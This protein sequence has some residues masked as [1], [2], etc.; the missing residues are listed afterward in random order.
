[1]KAFVAFLLIAVSSVSVRAVGAQPVPPCDPLQAAPVP[2]YAELGAPAAV[3]TWRD[4]EFDSRDACPDLPPGRVPLVVALASKFDG[5]K[6]LEDI[7]SRIGSI[8]AGQGL[9]YW[10]TTRQQWRT[11]V[12][13]A[14]AL[15]ESDTQQR[16]PDFKAQE[17]LSGETLYFLQNDT[18]S[19][20]RNG[21]ALTAKSVAPDRLIVEI[22]NTTPIRF[23][24]ITLFEPY[25]LRSIHY[26]DRLESNAWG[27]YG[28][29]AVR[30]DGTE[31]HEKSFVNR[32]GAY[33]RF[34]TETP[35]DREPPLAP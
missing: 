26:I 12:S 22:V 33:Y 24:L 29:M 21:Y 20:G 25:A 5:A 28:V 13:E 23:A 35:S 15:T 30:S 17:V 31:G 7:A 2:A 16:R 19:T 14:F 9:L 8:S 11:L 32:A 4:V 34:L 10:S 27:Y 3:R 18:L 1:M 6:S